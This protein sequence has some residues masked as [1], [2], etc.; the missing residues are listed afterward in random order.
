ME[1]ADDGPTHEGKPA[2][3]RERRRRG[4][5]VAKVRLDTVEQRKLIGLGHLDRSLL[6]GEVDFVI[7]DDQL[8]LLLLD[9]SDVEDFDTALNAA[10]SSAAKT[11]PRYSPL[12]RRRITCHP[13]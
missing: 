10:S 12:V 3:L 5:A 8:L 1:T 9:R 2:G 7:E 11:L 6:H 13:P 4:V